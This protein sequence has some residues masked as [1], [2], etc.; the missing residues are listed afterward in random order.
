MQ[1]NTGIL[2]KIAFFVQTSYNP[3]ETH[4]YD[5]ENQDPGDISTFP[6]VRSSILPANQH[7]A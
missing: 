2:Q 7:S 1:Q 6:D 3:E 5:T 4:A